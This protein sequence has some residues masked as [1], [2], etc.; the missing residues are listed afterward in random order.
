MKNLNLRTLLV[1]VLF[2]LMAVSVPV[3]SWAAPGDDLQLGDHSADVKFLQQKLQTKGFY[4]EGELSGH[5]GLDTL[6]AVKQ[7]EKEKNLN[8]DGK[9]TK[10]DWLMLAPEVYNQGGQAKNS[11]KV[12]LTYIQGNIGLDS[13]EKN[14]QFIDYS[15]QFNAFVAPDG[16]VKFEYGAYPKDGM[17]IAKNKNIKPLLVVHNMAHYKDNGYGSV[18]SKEVIHQVLNSAEKRKKTI[19]DTL[20]LVESYGFSGVNIDFESM[21]PSDRNLF[22]TFLTELRQVLAPKGY[23]VTAA[24]QA[25][26]ADNPSGYFGAFDYNKIGS[27]LDYA[28]VM[29]YDY[30]G[31]WGEPG[32]VAS[33]PWVNDV[34]KYTTSVIP[35]QKVL[36]GVPA[37]GY[38]WTMANNKVVASDVIWWKKANELTK[39]GPIQWDNKSSSPYLKYNKNNQHNEA[40]FENQYS[41]GIKLQL[42]DKY[43]LGGVALWKMGFEDATFWKTINEKL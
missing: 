41:L 36:M 38:N 31:P 6:V 37:Y 32:P 42:V 19:Q 3:T 7:F 12:V 27:I 24:I 39:Y 29:T 10:E 13:L 16:S 40:W 15:A 22:T 8:A 9:V 11:D 18:T 30:S 5:F 43:N 33:L 1:T 20:R 2:I 23:L 34:L 14:G 17:R 21:V 35:S 25:K 26:T 4:P 28:V